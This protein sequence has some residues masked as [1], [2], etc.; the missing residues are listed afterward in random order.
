RRAL[1]SFPTRR[2]SDLGGPGLPRGGMP[3][4]GVI[5]QERGVARLGHGKAVVLGVMPPQQAAAQA[6]KAGVLG[7]GHQLGVAFDRDIS[8]EL[9]R[10]ST[11]LNSS[12]VSI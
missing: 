10:K 5:L 9:D 11:R 3:C 8:G 2:S 4:G 6:V 7:H 1:L 12:H